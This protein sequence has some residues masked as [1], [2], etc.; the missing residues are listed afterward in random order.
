MSKI[1]KQPAIK[2]KRTGCLN[3]DNPHDYFSEDGLIAVGFGYAALER[4]GVPVYLESVDMIDLMTGAQAEAM[5]NNDP[6]H[7]WKIV[8]YGPLS[9]RTY[10]RHDV[11]K[12]ALIDEN[13]GFA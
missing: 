5:A 1:Q 8:L 4:D 13:Q 7:D 12:W 3:C 10:Q 6:D 2:S 11:G 9:G